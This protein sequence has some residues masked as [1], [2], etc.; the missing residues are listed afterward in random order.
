MSQHPWLPGVHP[1][2][3]IQRSPDVYEI[4]N[5]AADPEQRLEA[6][7]R[8]VQDWAGRDL[9]DVGC[10]TG[11]HL[12]R[13]AATA[14]HVHG[15]EPDDASRL[16]AIRRCAG[17]GLGNVSVLA[18]SAEWLPLRDHAVDVV[19]ARFAYFFGPGSEA[20]VRECLRVLRP[21]G[22]M[23]I[24]DNDLGSGT[25]ASWLARS[26]WVPQH[27]AEEVE[28]W[29]AARGFTKVRVPSRW[30]FASRD[31]L[32][33]VVRIEFPP[34][35]ADELLAEHHGLVVDCDYALYWRRVAP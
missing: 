7:M 16:A 6:A 25:F 14:R 10:G 18:G 1:A 2:P 20:G 9:L 30:E 32:E 22:V 13:F 21:S 11:F 4:E 5:R 29:W 17:A 24:V 34:A 8:A 33:A 27:R 23:F 15:V 19:Q 12:P 28:A 26:P 35:L 3:N 31:D